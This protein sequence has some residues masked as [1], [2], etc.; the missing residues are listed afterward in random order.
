MIARQ[1]C[2]EK[3][4]ITAKVNTSSKYYIQVIKYWTNGMKNNESNRSNKTS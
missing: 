3:Y 4:F 2:L 1:K